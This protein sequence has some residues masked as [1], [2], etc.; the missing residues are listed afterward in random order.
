MASAT[1]PAASPA[2][3]GT[4]KGG[5]SQLSKALLVAL[6]NP[7]ERSLLLQLEE[8][9]DALVAGRCG[10]GASCQQPAKTSSSPTPSHTH[11]HTHRLQECAFPPM[12]S[13]RRM[14]STYRGASENAGVPN[15][16]THPPTHPPTTP[17]FMPPRAAMACTVP[18]RV[19]APRGAQ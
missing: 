12:S 1:S 18:V 3:A 15:S 2:A 10:G 9:F 8:E 5:S 13:Y 14:L 11:T 16:H 17:Q 7:V 4:A 6:Q 19:P